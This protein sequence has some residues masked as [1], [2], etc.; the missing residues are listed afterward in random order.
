MAKLGAD[1]VAR[2]RHARSLQ[3]VELP[4]EEFAEILMEE[5]HLS[6]WTS[7]HIDRAWRP[8]T[9]LKGW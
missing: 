3:T 6:V 2:M 4:G 7:L 1:L 9:V 8:S 5:N